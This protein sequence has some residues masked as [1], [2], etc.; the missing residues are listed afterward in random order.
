MYAEYVDCNSNDIVVCL[1]DEPCVTFYDVL[2]AIYN[3]EIDPYTYFTD[4][5]GEEQEYGTMGCLG[6]DCV[7][8]DFVS[9]RGYYYCLSSR[10]M[11]LLNK[12][13]RLI[14]EAGEEY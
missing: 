5:D 2:I 8:V 3:S 10:D 12:N 6:N 1:E 13:R 4:F 9:G 14:L 7:A 11:A